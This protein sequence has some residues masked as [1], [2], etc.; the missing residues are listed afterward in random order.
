MLVRH[1]FTGKTTILYDYLK[2]RREELTSY[3]VWRFETVAGE[4]AQVAG[5]NAGRSCR[6]VSRK[7]F[8]A[9]S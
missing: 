1:G 8:I 7:S 5:Q 4:Q 9:L 3:A 2:K 6:S